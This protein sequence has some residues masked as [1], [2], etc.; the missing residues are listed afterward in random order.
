MNHQY[1]KTR[2]IH[3]K[4]IPLTS[5]TSIDK[6]LVHKILFNSSIISIDILAPK[7]FIF[8]NLTVSK[9]LTSDL[10]HQISKIEMSLIVTMNCIVT[11]RYLRL[12]IA[13][14]KVD[15]FFSSFLFFKLKSLH[16]KNKKYKHKIYMRVPYTH[17]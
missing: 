2:K 10:Q 17:L 15:D 9:Y 3:F 11:Y 13:F 5:N 14:C 4:S 16:K 1:P 6:C 8:S 12:K 7:I